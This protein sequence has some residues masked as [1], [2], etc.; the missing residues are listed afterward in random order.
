MALINCI[1][2]LNRSKVRNAEEKIAVDIL[3]TALEAPFRQLACNAG[4]EPSR[5]LRKIRAQKNKNYGVDFEKRT[6]CDVVKNGIIDSFRVTK[7]ALQN[8]SS[9]AG[10]L[11]STDAVITEIPKEVE[12]EDPHHHDEGGY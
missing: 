11:F 1:D 2:D 10:I 8:A 5:L 4:M 3:K 7:L 6:E 9:V 12:D